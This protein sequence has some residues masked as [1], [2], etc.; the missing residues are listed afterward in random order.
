M[1]LDK[2]KGFSKFA[3]ENNLASTLALKYN[4]AT[5]NIQRKLGVSPRRTQYGP[6]RLPITSGGTTYNK[7]LSSI[8]QQESAGK[9]NVVNKSSGALGLYQFMPNT[10]K[11][12]GYK[13]TSSQ[14]LN[15]P[16]LQKSYMHKFTQGNAKS[17]GINMQTMTS[18]Q[19]GYLAAAH[20]GGVGGARKIMRGNRKYGTT[21]FNG[22]TPYAYMNDV[23]RRMYTRN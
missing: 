3:V 6:T 8:M 13:G 1:T 2:L 12:L 14:F 17:L 15:N 5:A 9:F 23:L 19:A 4:R 22:K 16:A 18:Q 11:G 10:L 7:Y 20:Y 21:N